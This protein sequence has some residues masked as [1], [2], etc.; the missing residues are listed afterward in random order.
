MSK[1][2]EK[3]GQ[4]YV[5]IY[6]RDLNVATQK[7]LLELYNV[8]TPEELNWDTFPVTTLA[9]PSREELSEMLE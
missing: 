9:E 7:A 2:V 3:L 1:C 8:K 5:P 4:K 6:Y